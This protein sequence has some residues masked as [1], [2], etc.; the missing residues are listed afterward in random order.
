MKN[1]IITA[2][3]VFISLGSFAQLAETAAALKASDANALSAQFASSVDLTMGDKE[4]MYGKEQAKRMVADFFAKNAPAAFEIKHKSEAGSNKYLIG[5][6]KGKTGTFRVYAS[7]FNE[8]G[9]EVIRIL[10]FEN[11]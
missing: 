6:Y 1:S 4:G 8:S 3:L 9:R 10:K 2:A 11:E 7:F 5:T